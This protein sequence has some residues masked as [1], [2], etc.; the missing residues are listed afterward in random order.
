M[1]GWLYGIAV[2]TR[3]QFH[4]VDFYIFTNALPWSGSEGD[5]AE[6][7]NSGCILFE[8]SLGSELF[9]FWPVLLVLVDHVIRQSDQCSPRDFNVG[10][11]SLSLPVLDALPV[12]PGDGREHP[13]VLLIITDQTSSPFLSLSPLAF[14]HLDTG[15]QVGHFCDGLVVHN[16]IELVRDLVHLLQQSMQ[17]VRVSGQ[18]IAQSR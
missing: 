15:V 1:G 10:K 6:R 12:I 16:T 7:D 17:A 4:L 9:R 13:E 8:E 2:T 3:P 11:L 5:K 18:V 14:T